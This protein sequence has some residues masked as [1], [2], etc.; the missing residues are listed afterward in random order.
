MSPFEKCFIVVI[1]GAGSQYEHVK[2][3]ALI[4][5]GYVK[6]QKNF[7][8]Y[9]VYL[10]DQGSVKPILKSWQQFEQLDN[11]PLSISQSIGIFYE[12][13]SAYIFNSKTSAGKVMGLADFGTP[14]EV[15]DRVEF[16][17]SL[18]WK[19]AFKDKTKQAWENSPH[20]D[21]YKDLAATAQSE[22]ERHVSTV[23]NEIKNLDDTVENLILVG[24]S[25]LNCTHNMKVVQERVFKN[26]YIPPFPGDEG[27]GF[28]IAHY[29][30][31]KD[32]PQ[33]WAVCTEGQQV[34]Y[35]GSISSLPLRDDI[36]K[37]FSK[38]YKVTDI[39]TDYSK[40]IELLT[41][42]KII[43][44]YQG[45]SECGPRALGNRSIL[46]KVDRKD[47]KNYLNS[48]IKFRESFRPYACSC[49]FEKMGE[50]FDIP[51]NFDNSFMSFSVRVKDKYHDIF[52][53]V[54]HVDMTSR[55]Q[56]VKECQNPNYYKLIKDYGDKHGVYALLNTSL[57]VMGE[58]I[59]ETCHDMLNFMENTPVDAAVIEGMLIERK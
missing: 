21:Y 13:L 15:R 42:E 24:G 2:E 30:L 27:I 22:Y 17:K 6:G 11:S 54:A 40:V 58:P 55:M 18:D 49:I 45:R 5:R 44:W 1:D 41:Q 51:E 43:A 20:L 7:E 35:L 56:S 9:S 25:A 26:V 14:L 12:T 29:L 37:I 33:A 19:R 32:Y 8:Q 31:Y 34:S 23:L 52:R 38:N 39:G 50:Y 48:K 53:E 4:E 28:G 3:K 59:V 47:L 36:I 57:N 10:M 16:L 46:A